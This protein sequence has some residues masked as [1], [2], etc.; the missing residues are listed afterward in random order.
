MVLD[1]L[2]SFLAVDL[3]NFFRRLNV[4]NIWQG[5]VYNQSKLF[6]LSYSLRRFLSGMEDRAV[7]ESVVASLK[8]SGI[9]QNRMKRV[10]ADA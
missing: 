5:I 7:W 4:L 10:L 1:P 9:R 6:F 2:Q 8:T 3:G